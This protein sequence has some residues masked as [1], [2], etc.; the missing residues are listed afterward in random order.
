MKKDGETVAKDEKQKENVAI[1]EEND[2][3]TI[4]ERPLEDL[5]VLKN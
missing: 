4:K 1:K 5:K 2:V 3:A